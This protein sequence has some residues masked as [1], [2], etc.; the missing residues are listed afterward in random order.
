MSRVR[1]SQT[2]AASRH[3]TA[4][5]PRQRNI[6]APQHDRPRHT[7]PGTHLAPRTSNPCAGR[8]PTAA[9]SFSE[10]TRAAPSTRSSG[11]S[12]PSAMSSTRCRYAQLNLRQ[13][14]LPR[15]RVTAG[16]ARALNLARDAPWSSARG[17]SSPPS[18]SGRGRRSGCTTPHRCA[19]ESAIRSQQQVHTTYAAA[20]ETWHCSSS[21]GGR[22]LVFCHFPFRG[23]QCHFE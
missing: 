11:G 19:S 21:I 4:S 10:A 17:D 23:L 20:R 6:A 3:T 22:P 5:P 16:Q 7:W 2:R 8:I 14:R 18:V 13:A 9:A 15:R 1:S 12:R